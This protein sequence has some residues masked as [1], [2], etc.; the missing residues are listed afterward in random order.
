MFG[1]TFLDLKKDPNTSIVVAFIYVLG[2]S[3]MILAFKGII[4]FDE[5]KEKRAN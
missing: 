5:W 1:S 3:I 2:L 4:F